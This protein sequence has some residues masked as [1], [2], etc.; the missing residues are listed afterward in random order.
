[1]ASWFFYSRLSHVRAQDP[2]RSSVT[3][4]EAAGENREE[5]PASAQRGRFSN[6]KS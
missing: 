1:L 5:P 2:D 6:A 3:Q 4:F